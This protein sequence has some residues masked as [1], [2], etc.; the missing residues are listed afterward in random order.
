LSLFEQVHP[1]YQ[2]K[3]EETKSVLCFTAL[4]F[5]CP[6]K[7]IALAASKLYKKDIKKYYRKK[8]LFGTAEK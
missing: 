3:S 7:E 1:F 5:F 8:F 4:F 2:E 6:K